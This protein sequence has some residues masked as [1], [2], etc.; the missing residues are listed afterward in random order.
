MA[1][2]CNFSPVN[3]AQR[4]CDLFLISRF[5]KLSNVLTKLASLSDVVILQIALPPLSLEH[6]R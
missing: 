4:S 3:V 1:D 2:V 5:S 6:W